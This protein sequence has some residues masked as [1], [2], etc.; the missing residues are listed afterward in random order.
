MAAQARVAEGNYLEVAANTSFR[1][2]QAHCGQPA[3]REKQKA[4]VPITSA[5]IRGGHHDQ[6]IVMTNQGSE[7]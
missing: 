2:Q 4:A 6:V 5:T 3:R 7:A 1:G